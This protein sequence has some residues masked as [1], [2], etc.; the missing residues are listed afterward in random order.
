VKIQSLL[1]M[2]HEN[3]D[4]FE[5]FCKKIPSYAASSLLQT[6]MN[7]MFNNLTR[8][9]GEVKL[10]KFMK[11]IIHEEVDYYKNQ[12]DRVQF[13]LLN[14]IFNELTSKN[15]SRKYIDHLF[16]EQYSNIDFNLLDQ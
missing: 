12:L 4:V 7:Y 13:G 11:L 3:D 1:T 14:A 5:I 9:Q 8:S 16:K 2:I 6:I 15:E 10:C